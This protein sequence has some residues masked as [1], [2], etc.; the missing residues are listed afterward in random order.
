MKKIKFPLVLRDEYPARNME[1][2]RDYFDIERV[3]GCLCDGR[4]LTWLEDRGY[5]EVEEIKECDE[6]DKNLAERLCE[7]FQVK[8]EVG[9]SEKMKELQKA[10]TDFV[11]VGR[12][13]FGAIKQAFFGREEVAEEPEQKSGTEKKECMQYMFC[14]GC[15]M[16]I[17]RDVKF[18]NYCGKKNT[19][20][21]YN[22]GL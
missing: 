7:I 17:K 6:L 12:G 10:R 19:Y 4:L 2:L 15:G 5:R 1:E 11:L 14:A 3:Y 9:Y 21:R 18:C 13:L 22:D 8:Y 20:G 16:K